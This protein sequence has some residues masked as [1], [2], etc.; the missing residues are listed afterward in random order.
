MYTIIASQMWCLARFIPLLVGDLIAERD[1]NW[2]N[3]LS[4]L[5][6]I[7]YVFAPIITEDKTSY[8]EVLIDNFLREFKEI[9]PERSL[10]PKMHYLIHVP[11]WMRR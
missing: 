10:T 2:E 3:F 6:I 8:L 5:Q 7:E 11:L 1:G 9:Y 4:L